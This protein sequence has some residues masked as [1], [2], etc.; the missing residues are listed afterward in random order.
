MKYTKDDITVEIPDEFLRT[1]R[2][3]YGITTKAAIKMYTEGIETVDQLVEAMRDEQ[4]KPKTRK[5]RKSD[6]VKQMIMQAV[7]AGLESAAVPGFS[8]LDV[9]NPERQISFN[10]LDDSYE[11]TLTKKRS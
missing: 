9:K 3:Q 5:P 2:K 10:I 8:N 1:A 6:P 7:I 4:A 11:I